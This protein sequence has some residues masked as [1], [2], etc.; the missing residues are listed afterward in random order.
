MKS[1]HIN[2]INRETNNYLSKLNIDIMPAGRFE[3]YY[4][5]GS[6]CQIKHFNN[7]GQLHGS[8][9]CYYDNGVLA[10]DCTYVHGKK[11]GIY[12]EYTRTGN[13][14][15]SAIFDKDVMVSYIRF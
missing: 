4:P 9:K 8:S 1:D 12:F 7:D 14:L 10:V 3:T 2:I 6:V 5:N 15:F 11:Q 13:I